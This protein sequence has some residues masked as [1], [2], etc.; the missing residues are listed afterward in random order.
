MT[1]AFPHVPAALATPSVNRGVGFTREQ[2][3]NLGLTGRLPSAV[4]TLEQQAQRVWQQLQR[5]GTDLDRNLLLDQLRNRHEVLYFKVLSDH[6]TELMPVVYTPT[7]G[8]AIQKFSDEY[9]GQR[10]LYLSIDQPDEIAEAFQTLGLGPDEVDL[11]VCTDAEAILG[12]GDWGVNGIEIAV[13]KL[14]LYTA[15]GGIDPRRT[16]AVA[17]DVGTD[18]DQLL[19]DPFYLG[20]RHPRRRGAVYDEFIK[21]Y[22][23]T[24][25]RLFPHAILHFEDFG[26]ANAR[27]ILDTYAADYCVFNDD[28]QGTGAVVMAALYSAV[29]VT[30]IPMREQQVVVFGAGTAGLGI[31]D[32][33]RDAMVA[34]GATVEQAN[35]RIWPIDRPGLLFDD[36][37]DLRDFQKPYAKN[38]AQLGVSAGE[39]V[40]LLEAIKMAAPTILLGSSTVHG[41][42]T[43]DV[44]EAM[45]ASTPR[46]VI[47]PLSN[48]TSRMEAIPADVLAWSDGKALVATGSPIAPVEYNGTTYRIGQANNVLVFPGIGRGI[49]I[50]GARRV[51]KN[52][53]DAAAKAVASKTDPTGPGAALLPDM[54]NL[55]EISTAVAAAVY[56]AAVEDGVATKKH[57]D[58]VRA[59]L[60]TMWVPEYQTREEI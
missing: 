4:L 46:P 6:L 12:I 54:E 36:M 42:F 21:H 60:E 17:L 19:N 16:I 45:A 7:V 35:A 40:G 59:I 51:T 10:G 28:V 22:I 37:D 30:G 3:R 5:L 43:R 32:Q 14:A 25:D 39:R 57:H 33:I 26:P 52:M 13:G 44:I 23:Q 49:I 24:A 58:L 41:A 34:E 31:A 15:G 55:R 18:N 9:R 56:H 38:R 50:A 29:R 20:N 11:I 2:R 47:L 1:T 8:E 48:P 53:L 27:A